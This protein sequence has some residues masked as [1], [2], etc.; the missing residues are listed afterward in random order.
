[1][2]SLG[3]KS[4]APPK[5]LIVDD[6]EEVRLLIES[7][8]EDEGYTV[9]PC[10]RGDQ[11]IARV[12]S[13]GMDLVLLDRMLPDGDGLEVAQVIKA[14]QGPEY[15]IPTIIIS[16]LDSE[17]DK[18]E[19]LQVADDYISKP[20]SNDEL[21]AR[22]RSMLRIRD[23][24]N[25]LYRSQR[26]YQCLYD[27]VPEMCVSLNEE[28]RI[29]D[30]NQSFCRMFSIS[31]DAAVGKPFLEL[32]AKEERNGLRHYLTEARNEAG[33]SAGPQR[34]CQTVRQTS[35]GEMMVVGV[36]FARVNDQY[37]GVGKI[38]TMHD[39]TREVALEREQRIARQQL[40]RSARMASI[41]TLASGVAHEL[42]NPLAAIL[43]FSDALVQRFS[44]EENSNPQEV[45]QYL[46]IIC[47]EAIRCRDIVDNLSRFARESEC[48]I[49]PVS[50]KQ[51][52]ESAVRLISSRAN[53][54]G[55]SI[56]DLIEE[57]LVV[58]ADPQKL[59]QVFLNLLT[60]AVDF[61]TDG[62]VVQLRAEQPSD[63]K[64]RVLVRVEDNG[65]GMTPE[66]QQRAFD[67][68]FT[69]KE[70]GQGLGLG[71]AI[72]HRLMEECE[73]SID[74]VSTLNKGTTVFLELP[75]Q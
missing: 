50:L 4:S 48:R 19:G 34:I 47:G 44:S 28:E 35:S 39:L 64:G 24:Q 74:L 40:Y 66:V 65:R 11:A 14:A 2:S 37:T 63:R 57:D 21:V 6:N 5:V 42:N 62:I 36:R 27:N 46:E 33:E 60:N 67:P 75:A 25:E 49:R 43:G 68:F 23:L 22:V 45:K 20:F 8:L 54:R 32:F 3:E 16:A 7:L 55:I 10:E 1:M 17:Q 30:C 9:V 53:K 73:G 26:R 72:C 59:G 52:L 15:F 29:A 18:I 69:T 12:R 51:C 13:E 61:S 38:V 41:G 31:R 56:V 71:L 58:R 70:V